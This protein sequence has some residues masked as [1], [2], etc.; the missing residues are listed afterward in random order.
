LSVT[1]VWTASAK[2]PKA[3]PRQQIATAWESDVSA[4][5]ATMWVRM[6]T[7]IAPTGQ[8]PVQ[9]LEQACGNIHKTTAHEG[10]IQKSFREFFIGKGNAPIQA[11]PKEQGLGRG[12][13][14]VGHIGNRDARTHE[15]RREEPYKDRFPPYVEDHPV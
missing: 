4:T 6:Q 12:S 3:N 10:N 15:C 8:Q 14:I 13:F 11:T 1:G 5:M 7:S 9:H 2:N